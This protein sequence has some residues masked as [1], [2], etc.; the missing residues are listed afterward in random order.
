MGNVTK[1][2]LRKYDWET[3]RQALEDYA[4]HL[5]TTEP[6]AG[7]TINAFKSAAEGCPDEMELAE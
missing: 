2:D 5:E 6:S 3:I 7:N 4:S 1:A